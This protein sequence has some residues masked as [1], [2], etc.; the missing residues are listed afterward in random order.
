MRPAGQA[1]YTVRYGEFRRPY[2]AA[3]HLRWLLGLP[4]VRGLLEHLRHAA[5]NPRRRAGLPWYE[6]GFPDVEGDP[7]AIRLWKRGHRA[8][9][10]LLPPRLRKLVPLLARDPG[11]PIE[12]TGGPTLDPHRAER[13][14]AL[15][16]RKLTPGSPPLS[17]A[18]RQ[19]L[20]RDVRAL[21]PSREPLLIL[22]ATGLASGAT[23][24]ICASSAAQ[25][26]WVAAEP[27]PAYANVGLV[28]TY[29]DRGAGIVPFPLEGASPVPAE[30]FEVWVRPESAPPRT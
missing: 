17:N 22:P 29:S 27:Q 20:F 6:Y 4:Q 3:A 18:E 13:L 21:D 1:V 2:D 12:I 15:C 10:Y 9:A 14:Q 30:K 16:L 25:G 28:G 24:A 23:T 7:A 5:E 26:S 11:A 19:Q 8:L